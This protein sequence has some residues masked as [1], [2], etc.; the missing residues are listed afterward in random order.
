MLMECV[1]DDP[2]IILGQLAETDHAEQDA[3]KHRPQQ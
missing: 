2:E 3:G 1:A